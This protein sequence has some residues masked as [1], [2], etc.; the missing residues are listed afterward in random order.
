MLQQTN[1]HVGAMTRE[2]GV[3]TKSGMSYEILFF[4]A[5]LTSILTRKSN[6]RLVGPHFGSNSPLH[7]AKLQSRARGM[8]GFGIDW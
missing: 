5:T 6:A 3:H 2:H 7:G 8:L 1:I 4:L